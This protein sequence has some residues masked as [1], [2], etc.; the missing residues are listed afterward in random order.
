MKE[1]F[2]LLLSVHIWLK[3]LSRLKYTQLNHSQASSEGD[4][5]L[6]KLEKHISP[7]TD[8]IAAEVI[9]AGGNTLFRGPRTYSLYLEYERIT[10]AGKGIY[11][12]AYL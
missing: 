9:Q 4:V 2:C 7:G 1:Y 12:C 5:A 10:R 11:N 8:Q 3:M 6:E